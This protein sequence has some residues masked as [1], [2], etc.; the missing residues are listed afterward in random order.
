MSDVVQS[1]EKRW[2]F[3]EENDP[4]T[5]YKQLLEKSTLEEGLTLVLEKLNIPT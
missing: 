5:L 4:E 2:Q 3:G 1:M